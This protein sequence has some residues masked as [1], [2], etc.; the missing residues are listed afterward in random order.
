MTTEYY[1]K[2]PFIDECF[3]PPPHYLPC[4]LDHGFMDS[5]KPELS[6]EDWIYG[7]LAVC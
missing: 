2:L 6:L 7:R 5:S 3:S 4:T 1:S